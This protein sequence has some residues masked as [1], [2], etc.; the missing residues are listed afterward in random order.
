MVVDRL[1][2]YAHFVALSH[3]YSAE[4]VAQAYL[5]S[6][7]RLHGLPKSIVSDRDT[8]FLSTFWQSLFTTLG[9][10][11]HLSSA[12]H[13][14]SDGQTEVVNRCLEQYL[15]CMCVHSP[16]EWFKWLLLTEYWY[17]TSFYLASQLT[18]FEVLY[19]QPPPHHL[20]YLPREFDNVM[21]D[22]SMQAREAMIRQLH[23]KLNT[24]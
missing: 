16:K 3:P 6:I 1:S 12:Y 17:K 2:K 15:R 11:L 14:Q 10:D 13:P 22:R 24:R 23:F 8:I 21:V 4:T 20:P 18:P 5:D 19:G 9:V 7:F